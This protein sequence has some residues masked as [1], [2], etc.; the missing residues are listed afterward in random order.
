MER[1]ANIDAMEVFGSS[2]SGFFGRMVVFFS[3]GW[4]GMTLG[5]I[6]AE[7]VGI[8]NLTNPEIFISVMSDPGVL[9]AILFWPI[10]QLFTIGVTPLFALIAI[11]MTVG[12]F[13]MYIQLDGEPILWWCAVALTSSLMV[14]TAVSG[15]DDYLPYGVLFVLWTGVI[16]GTFHFYRRANP[17]A[18]ARAAAFL[19][20]RKDEYDD[21]YESI[22]D[23]KARL[24]EEDDDEET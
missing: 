23:I 22:A 8:D 24:D 1:M 13:C 17:D 5:F 4:V 21:G 18:V 9:L 14:V 10:A 3:A 6:S 12:M 7:C 2:V 19:S 20:G 16:A 15:F 11:L